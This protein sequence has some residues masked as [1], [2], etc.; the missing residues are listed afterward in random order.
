MMVESA[1]VVNDRVISKSQDMRVPS[2]SSTPPSGILHY[3]DHRGT[4]SS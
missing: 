1:A 3:L 4:L 2:T